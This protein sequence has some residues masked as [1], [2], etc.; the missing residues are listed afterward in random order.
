MVARRAW[1][2]ALVA[3]IAILAACSSDG[4]TPATTTLHATTTQQ[5]GHLQVLVFFTDQRAFNEA[6]PP[7]TS[8]VRRSVAA[9]N[10]ERGAIDALFAGPT[11]SEQA[12]GLRFVASGATGVS[13][14]RIASGVARVRLAGGCTSG[15]STLTITEE[16]VRTLLQ[17]P[18]VHT[19]KIYDPEGRTETP[20]GPVD[21]I[22]F[23][24]EP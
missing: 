10:P 11:A 21:S 6:V 8:P 13:S 3:A 16:L 22:P 24:L 9:S 18:Q 15:G 19:V 1:P 5:A 2:A 14:L 17:F 23:C 12:R 20:A 7:Y 4:G